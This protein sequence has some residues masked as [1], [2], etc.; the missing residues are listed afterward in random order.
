MTAGPDPIQ[1]LQHQSVPPPPSSAYESALQDDLSNKMEV[2]FVKEVKK[3]PGLAERVSSLRESG[4]G[5]DVDF[6]VGPPNN[7]AVSELF[8]KQWRKREGR[9]LSFRA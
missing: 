3:G 7:C 1:L 4:I 8:W 6:V 2:E 5:F 9:G